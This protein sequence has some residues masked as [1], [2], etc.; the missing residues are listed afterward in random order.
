MAKRRMPPHIVL[1][2]GMW[3]FVKK[4]AKKAKARVTRTRTRRVKSRRVFHMARR[5][6]RRVS[7]RRTG[8]SGS[9]MSLIKPALIGIGAAH[10]SGYVPINV[11]YKEEAAGAVAGYLLGGKIKGAAIGAGAV[12][13]SKMAQGSTGGSSGN[14]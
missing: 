2:N 8:M 13:L 6:G 4:G 12:F 9:V 10:L 5:R 1:P 14:Y 11:P 3:R 7:H